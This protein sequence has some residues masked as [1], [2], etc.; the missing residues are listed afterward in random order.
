MRAYLK[1][2]SDVLQL[3]DEGDDP[4]TEMRI[5]LMMQDVSRHPSWPAMA[6]RGDEVNLVREC[7]QALVWPAFRRNASTPTASEDELTQTWPLTNANIKYHIASSPQRFL[8]ACDDIAATLAGTGKRRLAAV[9]ARFRFVPD[10]SKQVPRFVRLDEQAVRSMF[11]EQFRDS[12]GGGN[13]FVRTERHRSGTL[14]KALVDEQKRDHAAALQ[15]LE[16]HGRSN[17]DKQEEK[18]EKA[19]VDEAW[20]TFDSLPCFSTLF[21]SEEIGE[22]W[23]RFA[24]TFETNGVAAHLQWRRVPRGCAV[25][26]DTRAAADAY[27][28]GFVETATRTD[29]RN[30][31]MRSQRRHELKRRRRHARAFKRSPLPALAPMSDHCRAQLDAQLANHGLVSVQLRPAPPTP[32]APSGPAVPSPGISGVFAVI[33]QQLK[34]VGAGHPHTPSTPPP[35]TP[36]SPLLRPT[37]TLHASTLP[38]PRARNP[39]TPC[40]TLAAR[41]FVY[42]PPATSTSKP[43]LSTITYI[44][45]GL[46]HA[47][48]RLRRAYRERAGAAQGGGTPP[49]AALPDQQALLPR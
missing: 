34:L 38:L 20:V 22:R 8:L 28:R 17:S 10:F 32:G 26:A 40:P 41:V 43:A 27:A 46:R 11:Q 9:N 35:P 16:D 42:L 4:E 12:F 1:A 6:T 5:D 44:G 24:Y 25:A 2:H 30:G 23:E 47:R 19:M 31:S 21:N 15:H 29:A 48:R 3:G 45:R 37:P 18:N 13:Y 14:A 36:P 33:A 7:R 39:T 49:A